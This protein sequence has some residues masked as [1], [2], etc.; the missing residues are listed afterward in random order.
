[1]GFIFLTNSAGVGTTSGVDTSGAKIIVLWSASGTG[2]TIS[3]NKSNTWT[4]LTSGSLSGT[5]GTFYYCNNPIVGSG[6]TFTTSGAFGSIFMQAF[7]GSIGIFDV[8]NGNTV[9]G[10]T[11]T[12]GS[13]TEGFNNELV[14]IGVAVGGSANTITN[15][16]GNITN[17]INSN[18]GVSYGG[19]MAWIIETNATS[20]NNTWNWISSTAAVAR[21]ASFKPSDDQG[22]SPI[23][24]GNTAIA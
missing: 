1:M 11:T 6:H 2:V 24:F 10:T 12:T 15:S 7:S 13:I 22:S 5:V 21:I 19:C 18:T 14:V 17:N 23:F 3:D 20:R 9:T 4:P 16:I 8:E